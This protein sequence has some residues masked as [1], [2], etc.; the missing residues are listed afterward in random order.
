MT[1]AT[2]AETG[3][4]PSHDSAEL[5]DAIA[6]LGVEPLS[7][8]L[9]QHV[10]D[11]YYPR[12]RRFFAKRELEREECADLT[13]ETFI[14]VFKG[15]GVFRSKAQFEAWLFRIAAN[16]CRNAHRSR[17]AAKRCGP[18][19]SLDELLDQYPSV[20]A[21]LAE[22]GTTAT[23]NPLVTYLDQERLAIVAKAL[24]QLPD[25]MRRCTILRIH[26]E[27]KY[28]E[29]AEVMGISIETVKAHLYQARNR[30]REF[31]APYGGLDFGD[32]S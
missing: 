7:D 5:L 21:R 23:R 31:L 22:H 32:F 11:A 8:E 13:Q 26:H 3:P 12:V 28:R 17:I 9:F 4:D 20:L 16:V 19:D 27:L 25:Q 30:L 10:V 6:R 18:E 14:R 2:I 15:K 1:E 29:I 24:H